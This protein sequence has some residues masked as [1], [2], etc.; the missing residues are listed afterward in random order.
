MRAFFGSVLGVIAMGVVLIA[1]GLLGP[2][3]AAVG[4][5]ASASTDINRAADFG[6]AAT[7]GL[8][9]RC[10]PGQR[11]ILQ[12]IN[13]VATSAACVADMTGGRSAGSL[14]QPVSEVR[15]VADE[16]SAPRQRPTSRVKRTPNHDWAKTA[17]VIGGSSASGAG[18][19]AIFGGKKGALV[20]AAIGGGAGT[21]FEVAR[22]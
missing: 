10:E 8:Q 20:G 1:Y 17:M 9:L 3:A 14:V 7:S 2:R 18:I 5:R 19:G 16:P 4:T 6:A 15:P 12:Q 11:A 22:R 13:G 21:L